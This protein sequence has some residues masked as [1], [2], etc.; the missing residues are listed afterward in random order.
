MQLNFID[1]DQNKSEISAG[2]TILFQL[3]YNVYPEIDEEEREAE[4]I[5][6]SDS[7]SIN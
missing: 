2:I 6:H 5:E 1:C 4:N 3:E 7:R